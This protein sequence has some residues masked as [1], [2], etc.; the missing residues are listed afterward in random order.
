MKHSRT[1]VKALVYFTDILYTD[2]LH[3]RSDDVLPTVCYYAVIK[4]VIEHLNEKTLKNLLC[5]EWRAPI[6]EI[7]FVAFQ[8]DDDCILACD[9]R[10]HLWIKRKDSLWWFLMSNELLK[11]SEFR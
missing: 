11:E 6:T 8:V 1:P 9:S 10:D 7:E 3:I 2:I 5:A 4:N